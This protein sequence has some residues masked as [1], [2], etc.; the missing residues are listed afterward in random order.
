MFVQQPMK[1]ASAE[2]LCHTQTDPMFSVLTVGTHNNCES[3]KHLIELPWVLPFLAEGKISGVTLQVV[4]NLQT[5]A[6]AAFGPGNYSPN[7]FVTY[8][9]FRAMIGLMAGS[10]AI[11]FFAWFFTRGGRV[12]TGRWSR[13]FAIGS[14]IAVPFPFFANSAGWVFTEM[15]RQPWIVHPNPESAGDPRTELIRLTVDMGVS[16]HAPATVVITLV[17]FTMLYLILAIA[18]FWLIRR[19][20]L[21]GPEMTTA[22]PDG[23]TGASPSAP[24]A[25]NLGAHVPQPVRFAERGEV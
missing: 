8:W 9:S 24:I 19:A 18:W 23:S 14:L 5:K 20:V 6:E 7:L 2:S 17:G 22:N 16:D 1:M 11:A 3:V 21:A 25:T 10:L 12:P 15:G 13:I 4:M